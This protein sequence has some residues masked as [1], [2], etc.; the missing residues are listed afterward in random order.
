MFKPDGMDADEQKRPQSQTRQPNSDLPRDKYERFEAWLRANGG[1]FDLVSNLL[2]WFSSWQT[3][4]LLYILF[5]KFV[6]LR[7]EETT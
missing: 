6:I 4:Y 7:A 3:K 2:S 5:R 1:E